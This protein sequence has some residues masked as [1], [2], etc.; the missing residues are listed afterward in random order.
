METS[1]PLDVKLSLKADGPQ[2]G[3]Q[4]EDVEREWEN[5]HII[6]FPP[7]RLGMTLLP[8]VET[9]YIKREEDK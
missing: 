2:A 3:Q 1:Y 6:L 5:Y 8:E 7:K 4:R 9:S